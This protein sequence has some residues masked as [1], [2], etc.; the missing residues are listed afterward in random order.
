MVDVSETLAPKSQQLDNIDLTN[1]PRTFT[2]TGVDLREN[3]EQPLWLHLA[4]FDRP[5]PPNVNMR[6]VIAHV[7]GRESDEWVGRRLT[8]F[9]DPRIKFGNDTTGGTRISHMSHIDKKVEVPV[10]VSKGRAATYTV[11]PLPDSPGATDAP[12]GSPQSKAAPGVS[13]PDVAPGVPSAEDWAAKI[14]ASDSIVEL[15][16]WWQIATP[17]NRKLIEKRVKTIET[18][19]LGDEA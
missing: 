12:A 3:A 13:A 16:Q 6:R 15:R 9:R 19:A 5:W 2:I 18:A 10:L 17:A 8:L 1:G 7:W 4:E 11:Q 14:A